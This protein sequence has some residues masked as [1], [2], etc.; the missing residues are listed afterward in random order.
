MS[1]LSA[2]ARCQLLRSGD[3]A[4][5]V[6]IAGKK[7]IK[8]HRKIICAQSPVLKQLCEEGLEV[9]TSEL[10]EGSA[11]TWTQKFGSVR[12][13]FANYDLQTLSRVIL[14]LYTG[15]YSDE[16]YPDLGYIKPSSPPDDRTNL[17]NKPDIRDSPDL[18]EMM[19]SKSPRATEIAVNNFKVYLC[20]K[21]LDIEP[22]KGLALAKLESCCHNRFIWKGIV[23]IFSYIHEHSNPEEIDLRT[24]LMRVCMKD[25]NVVMRDPELVAL[26]K[27]HEPV[28][29]ILL[30]ETTTK[31]SKLQ[32][33][34]KVSQAEQRAQID[35]LKEECE[36]LRNETKSTETAL[37]K[38]KDPDLSLQS[39]LLNT[40]NEARLLRA[41]NA[42]LEAEIS[43][44]TQAYQALMKEH[45]TMKK[46]VK[47]AKGKTLTGDQNYGNKIQSLQEKLKN[48]QTKLRHTDSSNHAW[49][50][51]NHEKKSL[52]SQ[53]Q[54]LKDMLEDA[55]GLLSDT[56]KCRR[57]GTGFCALLSV[58][59]ER[60]EIYVK[61]A[62]CGH[63]H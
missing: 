27:K 47:H 40:R 18:F 24:M 39:K 25:T 54:Y 4:D 48:A 53:V 20:A 9:G 16:S 5:C 45:E 57:C 29:W 22:L 35:K 30:E 3:F 6:V 19:S 33:A 10:C 36:R 11:L 42:V 55:E 12:L 28:A 58:N 26:L 13:E 52:E 50:K 17:E 62:D 8:V 2:D 15:K 43:E 51:L 34:E 46:E 38:F 61:C 31:I 1:I 60:K 23:P 41:R 63:T 49:G 7:E 37:V 56:R 59:R 21:T 44:F 32:A 14:F